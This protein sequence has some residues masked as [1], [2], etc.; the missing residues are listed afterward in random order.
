MTDEPAA[1]AD[2]RELLAAVQN[3]T[4]QVRMIQ[5]HTWLPLL[6]FALIMLAAIPVYWYAPSN[7][8]P[9]RSGP[10]GTTVCTAL[11]PWLVLAYWMVMLVLAYAVIAG[12]YVR[13]SRLRGVGTR[14][15]PY[16]VSGIV[17]TVL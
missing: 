14:I 15:R 13:Q 7:L 17:L 16:V 11:I 3:L 9:C 1:P 5:R 2:P 6:A 12:C 8:G 10:D 4:R